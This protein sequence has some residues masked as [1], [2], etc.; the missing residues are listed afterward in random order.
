MHGKCTV[1]ASV[2]ASSSALEC[3]I[4]KETGKVEFQQHLV[5]PCNGNGLSRGPWDRVVRVIYLRQCPEAGR[6]ERELKARSARTGQ[7]RSAHRPCD[8]G[9]KNLSRRRR[10]TLGAQWLGVGATSRVGAQSVLA[11]DTLVVQSKREGA[12]GLKA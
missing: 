2:Q 4:P 9:A 6:M 11:R 5:C 7:E 3:K 1:L 10:A 12:Q 8:C